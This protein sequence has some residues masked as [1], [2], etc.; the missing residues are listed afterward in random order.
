MAGFPGV[1]RLGLE[2]SLLQVPMTVRISHPRLTAALHLA[3]ATSAAT[4]TAMSAVLTAVLSA[5]LLTASP[6]AA[7]LKSPRYQSPG[8]TAATQQPTNTL[9]ATPA[10]TPDGTVVEDVIVRVNDQIISRSDMERQQQQ[11]DQEI[12]QGGAQAGDPTE[13]QKNMLRDLIDQ[14]LLLS[15]G[16]ELGVTGD[17]ELVRRLDELR[18]QNHLESLEDLEKAVRAQG[19][20]YEDFK[21]QIRN[22][23]VTQTVV[24]DEVSRKLQMTPADERRFYDAHKTEFSQPEQVRL[25]EILVPLPADANDA[26][27]AQA[28]QKADGVVTK[29]RAGAN[30]SDTAKSTSGG[31]T[32]SQGGDLGYFK[33][34]ALAQVLEDKTFPLKAG[35]FT[36]PIRTR[37]GFVILQATEHQQA[38]V[39]ELAKMEQQVQEAM[40]QEQM[41]PAL[42]AYLTHLREDAYVDIKPGF[43]DA[44]AST[45]QT[46]PLFS[47]YAAPAVK[48]KVAAAKARFDRRS[49]TTNAPGATTP[50]AT[51]ATVQ[52]DKRG[53]LQKIKREKIR[54]GQAPRV[55]L[56]AAPEDSAATAIAGTPVTAAAPGTVIAP[57]SSGNT[58]SAVN[59]DD[60]LAPQAPVQQKTRFSAHAATFHQEKLQKVEKRQADK[61]AAT[62]TGPTTQEQRAKKVQ[63]APLGLNGDTVSKK[64]K[65]RQKG[66]AKE[67][68]ADK[69]V[70]KAA[71]LVDNTP[72]RQPKTLPA[73]T[74]PEKTTADTTTLAPANQPAP[75]S[76][77][78]APA[79]PNTPAPT[80][81]TQVPQ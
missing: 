79:V 57:T 59:N 65:K 4:P 73:A 42:R 33:R 7:Q 53:R 63:A 13:R 32:A 62:P 77:Q 52:L 44:G 25:S 50:A 20:S 72:L 61:A 19:L 78:P 47:A 48:K 60:P 27:I 76:L 8:A 70:E 67:R 23:V 10:I 58:V 31:P 49:P 16:K 35:D 36:D 45:T 22:G 11:L 41:Q 21:A 54:Y 71:P 66:E 56:P 37:Q 75:G 81:N 1:D 26:A 12:R 30:F 18:K 24:R 43:V 2:E 17:T 28:Q 80:N 3:A 55:A 68:L 40:Y 6:L 9:P 34:G 5:I 74:A 69:P 29:L 38:G 51:L 46:K 15:R 64:K 39:P 14:Q